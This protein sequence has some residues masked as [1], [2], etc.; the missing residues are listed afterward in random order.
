MEQTIHSHPEL[1]ANFFTLKNLRHLIWY[2]ET[3]VQ[4]YIDKYTDVDYHTIKELSSFL[5]N[6]LKKKYANEYIYKSIL[7]KKTVFG[8]FSPNTT[9]LFFEYPIN[10]TRADALLIN[11]DAYVYEIKSSYD[12]LDKLNRQIEQYVNCFSNI[13]VFTHNKHLKNILYNVPDYVGISIL[14][15]KYTVTEIKKPKKYFDKI[16]HKSIFAL[17]H[18]KEREMLLSIFNIKHNDNVH[19][20]YQYNYYLDLFSKIPIKKAHEN[21]ISILKK[22]QNTKKL[23]EYC[24]KLPEAF[25]TL[26]FSHKLTKQEWSKFIFLVNRKHH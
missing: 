21:I 23:A 24:Y 20:A 18:K 9:S 22:R 13:I 26:V 7:L 15:K 6:Y 19:P 2:G 17:L 14:S 25:H 5:F 11:G 8:R 12:S 10:K 3:D 1:L 16:N 4:K